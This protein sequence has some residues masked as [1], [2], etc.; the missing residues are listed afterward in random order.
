M[1]ERNLHHLTGLGPWRPDLGILIRL[2]QPPTH[3]R[4]RHTSVVALRGH[5]PGAP[6]APAV[7]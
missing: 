1:A 7:L 5:R 6:A 4:A 3:T 2:S